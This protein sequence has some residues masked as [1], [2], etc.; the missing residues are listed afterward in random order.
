[1]IFVLI[2]SKTITDVKIE[3]QNSG[4]ETP[5]IYSKEGRFC[6]YCPGA[7][8]TQSA[9]VMTLSSKEDERFTNSVPWFDKWGCG[10]DKAS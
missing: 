8:L 6:P 10:G 3:G 2:N 1:M 9:L 4:V 5:C 7:E